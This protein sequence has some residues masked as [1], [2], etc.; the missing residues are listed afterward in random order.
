MKSIEQKAMRFLSTVLLVGS[1]LIPTIV[2]STEDGGTRSVFSEMSGG[3]GRAMGGAYAALVSDAS[4]VDW[5]AGGLAFVQRRGAL[6][7]RSDYY[8]LQ[9]GEEYA[10]L[11]WPDWR[12]GVGAVSLQH[13]GIDGIE[14]RDDRNGVT[15]SEFGSSQTQISLGYGRQVGEA[16]GVGGTFRFQRYQVANAEA[17]GFAFDLGTQLSPGLLLGWPQD[18]WERTT[19]GISARN[20]MEPEIRLDQDVTHDPGTWRVGAAYT[21]PFASSGHFTAAVDMERSGGLDSRIHAGVEIQLHPS[22]ALRSGLTQGHPTMGAGLTWRDLAFDYVLENNPIGDVHRVGFSYQFGSTLAEDQLSYL[23]AEEA[24]IQTRMEVAFEERQAGRVDELLA[25]ARGAL[26]SGDVRATLQSLAVVETLVPD[27][28]RSHAL[29]IEAWMLEAREL[30]A[31]EKFSEAALAYNRVLAI[32]P[33]FADARSAHASAQEQSDVRARRSEQVR[34]L[35]AEALDAFSGRDLV[36]S[37]TLLDEVLSIDPKDDDAR[38][39]RERTRTAIRREIEEKVA[40]ADQFIRAG[41][42][43]DATGLLRKV[44][45]LDPGNS[46]VTRLVERIST[47]RNEMARSASPS[48]GK[49]SNPNSSEASSS[50]TAANPPPPTTTRRQL[51]AEEKK[52]LEGLYNR[53]VAASQEQRSTDAMRYFEHVYAAKPDF[54][55]VAES[56]KRECLVVGMDHFASSRLDEAIAVWQRALEVDPNDEKVRGYLKRALQNRTRTE[57][58]L[59]DNR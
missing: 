10:A 49:V 48:G 8:G 31:E 45:Q 11:V 52:E 36:R 27:D 58:L 19:V 54:P 44:Q 5:N 32:D 42:L 39:M 53:G 14:G 28:P 56:L 15:E 16:W 41:L 29:S 55:G 40:Q 18:F 34:G 30:E 46:E 57:E 3:R 9:I 37:R 4:S 51:S 22:I 12:W 33:D 2:H 23:A 20:L 24:R 38:S 17:T 35:F 25:E 26:Q 43:T 50:S 59:R 1:I 7:L 13:F 21:H 6:V 47:R